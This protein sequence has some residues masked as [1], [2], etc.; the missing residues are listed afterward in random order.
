MHISS[1]F[2]FC[3]I[4]GIYF[5]ETFLVLLLLLALRYFKLWVKLLLF[6][7]MF[8]D[9]LFTLSSISNKSV[10][11]NRRKIFFF[12]KGPCVYNFSSFGLGPFVPLETTDIWLNNC[13]NGV[14]LNSINPTSYRELLYIEI[15]PLPVKCCKF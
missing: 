3:T 1:N 15:S 2:E 4:G 14:K 5:S 12:P 11:E 13:H 6:Y 9:S 7:Y 8:N 10:L